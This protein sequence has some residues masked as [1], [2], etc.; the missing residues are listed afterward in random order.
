MLD[1]RHAQLILAL[2]WETGCFL[3]FCEALLLCQMLFVRELS[4]QNS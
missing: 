2:V 1:S 3:R 4:K